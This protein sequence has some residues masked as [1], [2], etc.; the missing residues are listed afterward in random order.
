MSREPVQRGMDV[1]EG[2]D[3]TKNKRANELHPVPTLVVGKLRH[4]SR[5]QRFSSELRSYSRS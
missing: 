2:K 1:Q 5:F 4:R 3:A